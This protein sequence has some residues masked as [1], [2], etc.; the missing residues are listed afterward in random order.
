[1]TPVE[2]AD[3]LGLF[4]VP[5][6]AAHCVNLTKNDFRILKEK[7]VSA[8]TNPASNMKLG[9]GFAPVAE[10][11]RRGINVCLG[12]DGAASNNSLNMFREIGFLGLIHK[13]NAKSPLAVSAEE[14]IKIATKNGAKAVGMADKI[15]EIKVGMDADIILINTDTPAFNPRNNSI[16]ALV[17]GANGSETDT[18]MVK[19]EILMEKRILTTID[20]EKVYFK[21][22]KIADRLGIGEVL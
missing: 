20:E 17:Y 14:C 2:Y 12:T 11:L 13:G 18:V 4:D 15:G 3:W 9:N 7:N 5:A 19:G 8:A 1:M 21:V 22:G 10:M 16:S 6:I